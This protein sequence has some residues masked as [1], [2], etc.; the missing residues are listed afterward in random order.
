MR[1]TIRL[2]INTSGI[3]ILL[4][5]LSLL[6]FNILSTNSLGKDL[7]IDISNSDNENISSIL[8]G[9][10]FIVTIYELNVANLLL[11]QDVNITF[12][13]KHYQISGDLSEYD[14]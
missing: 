1:R 4:I 5:L 2:N 13:N 7:L 11:L 14:N 8:E 3:A 6:F 10:D 12:N 9:E